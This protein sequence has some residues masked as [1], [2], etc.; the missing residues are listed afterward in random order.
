MADA[1]PLATAPTTTRRYR[2]FWTT[3]LVDTYYRRCPTPAVGP[4]HID[5]GSEGWGHVRVEVAPEHGAEP[6]MQAKIGTLLT[7]MAPRRYEAPGAL[8]RWV[9]YHKRRRREA[10][11]EEEGQAVT[12]TTEDDDTEGAWRT[13]RIRCRTTPV[14]YAE[15]TNRWFGAARGAYNVLLWGA[16]NGKCACDMTS[17]RVLLAH[18]KTP[19]PWMDEAMAALYPH[20]AP[21][22]FWELGCREIVLGAMSDLIA[23]HKTE[24]TKTRLAAHRD[25]AAPATPAVYRERRRDKGNSETIHLRAGCAR[26]A[27]TIK[28]MKLDSER[29][30][31]PNAKRLHATVRLS[32]NRASTIDMPVR[33]RR[34]LLEEVMAVGDWPRCPADLH[35]DKRRRAIYLL[36]KLERHRPPDPDA[37][38]PERKRVVVMDPGV[39]QFQTFYEPQTGGRGVL[40]THYG[41]DGRSAAAE[42]ARRREKL[43]RLARKAADWRR[44]RTERR[45]FPRSVV[46]ERRY[47]RPWPPPPSPASPEEA[48][49]MRWTLSTLRLGRLARRRAWQRCRQA[50][51]RLHREWARWEG[52]QKHMHYVT[53]RYIWDHWD[54]AVLTTA[55]FGGMWRRNRSGA[56]A[57]NRP[58]GARTVRAGMSWG[59]YKFAE[60][61][62]VSAFRRAGKYVVK[63]PE[64]HTTKTCG[65]CGHLHSKEEIGGA[66]AFVCRVCD[67]PLDRD[68]NAARN[69]ALRAITVAVLGREALLESVNTANTR[70]SITTAV[71]D[72]ETM[73]EDDD[74]PQ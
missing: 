46:F 54:T 14:K 41:H 45:E 11:A 1:T 62:K 22:R 50:K 17:A 44:H 13:F 20:A 15:L 27:G 38:A 12:E 3:D 37:D 68:L 53:A 26:D 43:D 2:P 4:P 49:A 35:W 19:V 59:H 21:E 61:L 39:V 29:N 7:S 42:L 71:A 31:D 36:V 32:I 58:F 9:A 8:G 56:A 40:L 28:W 34:W 23:A 60:R 52:Y 70:I 30:T 67:Q 5:R 51:R 47:N 10:E 73:A 6:E 69:I 63:T 74:P 33:D 57:S 64:H 66:R 55:R 48:R 16:Q 25:Q 65:M 72:D 18:A 24:E